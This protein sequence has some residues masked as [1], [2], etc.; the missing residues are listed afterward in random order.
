MFRFIQIHFHYQVVSK[1]F[2][3]KT[4]KPQLCYCPDGTCILVKLSLFQA[5]GPSSIP[6]CP[7]FLTFS[8]QTDAQSVSVEQPTILHML[9]VSLHY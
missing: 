9:H 2:L 5:E 8:L 3:T 7:D 1:N 4:Q 6:A